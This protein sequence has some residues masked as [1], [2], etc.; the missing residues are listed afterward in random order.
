[1]SPSANY[2]EDSAKPIPPESHVAIV[3]AGYTQARRHWN[4]GCQL[5]DSRQV[6]FEFR[7]LTRPQKT[8]RHAHRILTRGLVGLDGT[9]QN[10]TEFERTLERSHLRARRDSNPQPS[11]P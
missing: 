2:D 9:S 7:T 8:L 4:L 5:T 11:D 3:V 6:T 10:E 1:V